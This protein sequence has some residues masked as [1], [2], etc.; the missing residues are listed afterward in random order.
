MMCLKSLLHTGPSLVFSGL[1]IPEVSGHS[2][3]YGG[4]T[5]SVQCGQDLPG[6]PEAEDI[7]RLLGHI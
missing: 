2:D 1:H 3:S 6:E 5:V 4:P 7:Q